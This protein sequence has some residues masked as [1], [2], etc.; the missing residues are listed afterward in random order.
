MMKKIFRSSFFRGGSILRPDII[1]I[2]DL[3]ITYKK[4]K[5]HLLGKYSISIPVL[6]IVSIEIY[7][8]IWGVQIIIKSYGKSVII[9]KG[10]SLSTAKKIKKLIEE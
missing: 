6:N 10:F 5:D 3:Y 2:D 8:E 4:R 1:E 9:V 7:K